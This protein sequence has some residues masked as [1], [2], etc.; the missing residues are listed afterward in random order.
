MGIVQK[1]IA[2]SDRRRTR[3]HD[4]KGNRI[5]FPGLRYAPSAFFSA[6]LSRWGYRS[7]LPWL[8]Y[9]AIAHIESLLQPDWK[10]LEFGAGAST[11]W[12]AKRCAFVLSIE[13]EQPW[14]DEVCRQLREANVQ[15]AECRQ[16]DDSVY[17]VIDDRPDGSFDF[18]LVDG[19]QRAL[20]ARTAWR[21]VKSKGWI[22][23]D[24]S[25][26]SGAEVRDGETFL[27]E[28]SKDS[29]TPPRY[30]VDFNPM[31]LF[32]QQGLLVQHD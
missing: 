22:Y 6:V 5:D 18:A 25:D 20:T 32:A 8:G 21:L 4:E 10:V 11:L 9:R 31:C 3:L 29:P 2:G 26:K 28:K 27:L 15:N 1:I 16:R 17:H 23:Y 13:W 12:F 30:F 24:N 7:K 14:R 19:R